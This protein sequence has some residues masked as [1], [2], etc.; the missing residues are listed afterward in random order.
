MAHHPAP[1]L[2]LPWSHTFEPG[3]AW[4]GDKTVVPHRITVHRDWSLSTPHADLA[5]EQILAALG[6]PHCTCLSAAADIAVVR[7]AMELYARR[8]PY[9]IIRTGPAAWQVR[10]ADGQ[11]HTFL[12]ALT[13]A[14]FIRSDIGGPVRRTSRQTRLIA[15]GLRARDIEDPPARWARTA[16]WLLIESTGVTILWQA[17]V[18]PRTLVESWCARGKP[19]EQISAYAFLTWIY[20]DRR[21][22]ACRINRSR[23]RWS[24]T[25][26]MLPTIGQIV[27][28]VVP[29]L[30][31][32]PDFH[33]A[34]ALTRPTPAQRL[35]R[36]NH[37]IAA[38]VESA[39]DTTRFTGINTVV[40]LGRIDADEWLVV[41]DRS[42]N[43]PNAR[44][45]VV[46]CP[47]PDIGTPPI[48]GTTTL[49]YRVVE[50]VLASQRYSEAIP[51][52]AAP[53]RSA[54]GV[55]RSLLAAGAESE[56]A[57]WL[58]D[59]ELIG[60]GLP[61]AEDALA[62][63]HVLGV[64]G[65]LPADR[66][67]RLMVI[68][69][70]TWLRH[71]PETWGLPAHIAQ[72]AQHLVYFSDRVLPDL[73]PATFA[74]TAHQWMWAVC[75]RLSLGISTEQLLRSWSV[76]TQGNHITAVWGLGSATL[77]PDGDPDTTT[78]YELRTS[79]NAQSKIAGIVLLLTLA[80]LCPR[81]C[82]G[83][84][85]TAPVE[86][87]ESA[88]ARYTL[89]KVFDLE[90]LRALTAYRIPGQPWTIARER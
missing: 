46:R 54:I 51:D 29:A 64:R 28:G 41:R 81:A 73:D 11:V 40:V 33:D 74:D 35:S 82:T 36:R 38:L 39:T 71:H 63:L 3:P 26:T 19:A 67:A 87:T 56:A 42:R 76:T 58:I 53:P 34:L 13:A 89:R 37:E 16:A 90:R 5:Q 77:G 27:P 45:A 7:E 55:V 61:I 88:M 44:C 4:Y 85:R 14:A 6:G 15:A 70:G 75:T 12:S 80:S 2:R 68:L 60:P 83:L 86:M 49:L 9:P 17:G 78:H 43:G 18:H 62:A 66:V 59:A 25:T 50:N 30:L 52:R 20:R 1:P 79:P 84:P 32:D 21:G 8:R 69:T 10:M 65:V 48:P 22:A 31:R 72:A 23:A 47:P 24:T 57:A